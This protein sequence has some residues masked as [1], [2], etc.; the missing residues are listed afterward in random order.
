MQLLPTFSGSRSLRPH[1]FFR[2]RSSQHRTWHSFAFATACTLKHASDSAILRQGPGRCL[3]YPRIQ[4]WLAARL[5]PLIRPI[6]S[7]AHHQIHQTHISVL[8]PEKHPL[9]S[10]NPC[11]GALQQPGKS[12]F[13]PSVLS[14]PFPSSSF[15]SKAG[16]KKGPPP[17]HQSHSQ[18][19]SALSNIQRG[20]RHSAGGS[21]HLA[22]RG[23]R[24]GKAPA[25]NSGPG[26]SQQ[27]MGGLNQRP[28]EFMS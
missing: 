5:G 20:G 2:G 21:P 7:S 11:S 4:S 1:I 18:E 19:C 8:I 25:G 9:I 26:P 13:C 15:S 17:S 3:P 10:P 28:D 16:T 27:S 6:I 24:M 23:R 12:G 22:R 14:L